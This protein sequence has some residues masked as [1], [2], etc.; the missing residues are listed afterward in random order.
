MLFITQSRNILFLKILLKCHGL[1]Y[2]MLYRQIINIGI[3]L[4][5]AYTLYCHPGTNL[6]VLKHANYY[7]GSR[8]NDVINMA[9]YLHLSQK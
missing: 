6:T 2:N 1:L 5:K 7:Q 8:D 4:V 9:T 3:I